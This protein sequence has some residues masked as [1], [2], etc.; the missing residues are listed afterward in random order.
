MAFFTL[1]GSPITTSLL[2]CSFDNGSNKSFGI[3]NT[4]TQDV[5]K[6]IYKIAILLLYASLKYKLK[7]ISRYCFLSHHAIF[8]VCSCLFSLPTTS[9][10]FFCHD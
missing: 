10:H 6:Y 9:P 1:D 4:N 7:H 2:F 3:L 8:S 5:K